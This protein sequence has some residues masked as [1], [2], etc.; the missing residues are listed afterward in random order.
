M[1]AYLA[2]FDISDD[3]IRYRTTR[4]LSAYGVRVQKSV[5]EI[6]VN[7]PGELTAI[8]SELT[9]ILDQDDDVRFYSL[10]LNCR[11]KSHK[12]DDTRVAQFPSV[13]IL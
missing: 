7:T 4:C 9:D 12:H 6:T 8:K 2:C 13:V 10:C 3:K 5:F 11:K 1:N